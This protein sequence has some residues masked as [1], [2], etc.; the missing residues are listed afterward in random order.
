MANILLTEIESIN[1]TIHKISQK[2]K[3]HETPVILFQNQIALSS[4]YNTLVGNLEKI[5]YSPRCAY[6]GSLPPLV[7]PQ[8]LM[9]KQQ[10]DDLLNITNLINSKIDLF[11]TETAHNVVTNSHHGRGSVPNQFYDQSIELTEGFNKFRIGVNSNFCIR[12]LNGGGFKARK[13][14]YA[15]AGN[16]SSYHSWEDGASDNRGREPGAQGEPSNLPVDET[17]KVNSGQVYL[18]KNISDIPNNNSWVLLINKVLGNYRNCDNIFFRLYV[19]KNNNVL[20]ARYMYGQ[21][22]GLE[23]RWKELKLSW[24]TK[25]NISAFVG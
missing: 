6:H 23:Y 7:H 9:K 13:S 4:V 25:S 18:E 10:I 19:K 12:F 21:T 16:L 17:G 2:I 20:T 5:T 1:N 11:K 14:E 8:D 22:A 3:I 24:N 15:V